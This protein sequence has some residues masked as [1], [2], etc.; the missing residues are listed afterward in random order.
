TTVRDQ[1]SAVAPIA[2]WDEA[3]AAGAFD[4]P[5]L[6]YGAVQYY[7]DWAFDDEQGQGVEPEADPEH[8][9]RAVAVNAIFAAQHLKTRTFRRW[10][11][12]ARFVTEAHR[13][14][15]RVTGHCAYPLPVVAAGIDSKEHLGFCTRGEERI[16]DDFVQLY[17][18]AHIAVV[19]TVA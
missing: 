16:Y 5:R 15:L 4:G 1:G 9:A 19:P 2:A 8:L 18:A 12:D 10:D 17:S 13:H 11:I 7:S 3:I 6:G 14:G